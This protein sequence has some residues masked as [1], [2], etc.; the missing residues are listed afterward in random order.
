MPPKAVPTH[1]HQENA[2][3]EENR[4]RDVRGAEQNAT[5]NERDAEMH[6][7]KNAQSIAQCR[8]NAKGAL[9]R[10]QHAM[11]D[12]IDKIARVR[13]QLDQRILQTGSRMELIQN[14]TRETTA[15]I[16]T[17]DQ[18]QATANALDQQR[19]LRPTREHINDPVSTYIE[20]TQVGLSESVSALRSRQEK[21]TQ[22]LAQLKWQKLQLERDL[23]G[24][25]K[26]LHVDLD[27]LVHEVH[28]SNGHTIH[29]TSNTEKFQK[30]IKVDHRYAPM[31]S[32]VNRAMEWKDESVLPTG[33]SFMKRKG[34]GKITLR[35]M[36][37]RQIT[38]SSMAAV[39]L[40][41]TS[42]SAR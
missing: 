19:T 11:D 21:E 12:R 23:S 35:P 10:T 5:S 4:H 8:L 30:A 42:M 25:T 29:K 28:N 41:S 6:R 27:C 13:K 2:R 33:P 14:T 9:A 3:N 40:D 15:H 38:A 39:S 1:L 24:K 20:E 34:N 18:A 26:A 17:M 7:S 32:S 16:R 31:L 36:S 37:S 22:T